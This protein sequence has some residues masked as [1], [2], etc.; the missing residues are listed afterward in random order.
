MAPRTPLRDPGPFFRSQPDWARLFRTPLLLGFGAVL[1]VG[2]AYYGVSLA[3]A[4]LASGTVVVD[5]PAYPGDYYCDSEL[6]RPPTGCSE[7]ATLERS[8]SAVFA[9]SVREVGFMLSVLT[10][11]GFLGSVIL[12]AG[13]SF[14][15]HGEGSLSNSVRVAAWGT[16]PF[17]LV[18]TANALILGYT[19]LESGTTYEVGGTVGRSFAVMGFATVVASLW[20]AYLWYAGLRLLHGVSDRQATITVA[21]ML[22]TSIALSFAIY[23]L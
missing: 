11:F 12:L 10:F 20:A 2:G 23:T 5:N 1:F 7:P 16:V 22:S 15:Y 6:G 13:A 9:E 18:L 8:Q 21:G 17:A 14:R 19:L 4:E 3:V